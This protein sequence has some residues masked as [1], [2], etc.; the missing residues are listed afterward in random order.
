M[1]LSFISYIKKIA[2]LR[3]SSKMKNSKI[4]IEHDYDEE[5]REKRK[6]V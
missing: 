3:N 4:F 2:L 1:L 6:T 5:T